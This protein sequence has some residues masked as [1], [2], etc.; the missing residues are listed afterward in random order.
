MKLEMTGIIKLFG[1]FF[2]LMQILYIR[3][4]VPLVCCEW[5]YD[6]VTRLMPIVVLCGMKQSQLG[7]CHLFLFWGDEINVEQGLMFNLY[8]TVMKC[9]MH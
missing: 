2:I 1:T 6:L 4:S 7:L 5:S 3:F 9:C 8:T